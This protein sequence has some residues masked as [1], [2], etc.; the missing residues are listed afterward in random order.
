MTPPGRPPAVIAF[1]R[2]PLWWLAGVAAFAGVLAVIDSRMV[3]H[4]DAP[5]TASVE[6]PGTVT[7]ADPD[8]DVLDLSY[9]EAGTGAAVVA[10]TVVHDVRPFP[11]VGDPVVLEVSATDPAAVR[12]IAD[13][14]AWYHDVPFYAGAVA[15]PLLFLLTRH[16]HVRRL[17]RLMASDTPSYAM[18]G[19]VLPPAGV[20]RRWRLALYA[21]DASLG[22]APVCTLAL[23]S[24]PEAAAG[25]VEAE[26]KGAPRPY[27]LVAARVGDEVVWPRGRALARTARTVPMSEALL[28]GG[29]GRDRQPGVARL[30]RAA[31]LVGV[32]AGLWFSAASTIRAEEILEASRPARATVV[33]L[34]ADGGYRPRLAVDLSVAGT[35]FRAVVEDS[36]GGAPAIGSAVDVR[37]DV[38]QP[39]SAW[40][41][42]ERFPLDSGQ[43]AEGGLLVIGLGLLVV[44]AFV[45]R[46]AT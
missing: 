28:V 34:I 39:P 27:G 40:A 20:R 5:F 6:R 18:Q 4:D 29:P 16:R 43:G 35:P 11:A 37:Y 23:I 19:I 41:R 44:A 7:G 12:L 22:A 14:A 26:V 9:P 2:R 46:A 1:L 25:P 10:A 17:E 21:L 15:L 24:A 38:D 30:L 32:A 45:D 3:A 42:D 31:G 13:R 36:D 33:E 8:T